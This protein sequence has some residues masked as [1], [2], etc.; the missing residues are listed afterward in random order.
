[1]DSPAEAKSGPSVFYEKAYNRGR[2]MSDDFFMW[3]EG[4]TT[5]GRINGFAVDNKTHGAN[6][7]HLLMHRLAHAGS[8]RLVWRSA[9]AHDVA[10]D[11]PFIS[12]TNEVNS[13]LAPDHN[14][15]I[16]SN[17]MNRWLCKTVKERDCRQAVGL[18]DGI[19]ALD[20]FVIVGAS[21]DLCKTIIFP[22]D[23][24]KGQRLI[25][26]ISGSELKGKKVQG[27]MSFDI[28]EPGA[29]KQV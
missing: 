16:A 11:F 27:G 17:P 24:L 3:G 1:M 8:R 19:S 10:G 20:K 13:N 5:E 12:P 7:C 18:A 6:S 25:P 15:K 29:W 23:L 26:E 4:I 21:K 28:S 9:W 14:K 2:R 22:E